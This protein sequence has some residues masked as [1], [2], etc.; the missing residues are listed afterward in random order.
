MSQ[1]FTDKTYQEIEAYLLRSMSEE[2]MASFE[3]RMDNDALLKKEVLLQQSLHQA[4]DE[5]D[6][7]IDQR[8]NN[9]EELAALTAKLSSDE[10]KK[11]SQNITAA[12][13]AYFETIKNKSPQKRFSFYKVGIA[14]TIL[15]LISI[16]FL[17]PDNS[18]ASQYQSLAQWDD[19]PSIIEKGDT[20]NANNQGEAF[21]RAQNY[22]EVVN[23]F[24]SSDTLSASALMYLGIAYLELDSTAEALQTFDKLLA[25]PSIESSRAYWYKLLVFVKQGN[26]EK[27]K[28]TLAII[29]SSKDNYNYRK[30]LSLSAEWEEMLK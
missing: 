10:Y 24:S 3:E 28:E 22:Q 13:E 5:N 8:P 20:Q 11:A 16:P 7:S 4:F 30:A 21:F 12:S 15:L 2:E 14:A 17:W 26:K 1:E 27:V 29:L 18:L 9:Q 19:I 23:H 25:T 6:W